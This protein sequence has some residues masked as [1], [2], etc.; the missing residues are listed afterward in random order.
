M[1][2]HMETYKWKQERYHKGNKHHWVSLSKTNINTY[3]VASI[4]NQGKYIFT[5][6]FVLS[7]NSWKYLER[8][9][10]NTPASQFLKY[11]P[12][13]SCDLVT[14]LSKTQT[15]QCFKQTL[16]IPHR[17]VSEHKNNLKFGQ[18]G[19]NLLLCLIT[20]RTCSERHP[21]LCQECIL[22]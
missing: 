13:F 10:G 19:T 20:G 18:E 11:W 1:H 15:T 14:S 16:L 9:M 6:T 7:K 3:S 8:N 17:R 4:R 22:G 12:Q 21:G 5:A 2:W